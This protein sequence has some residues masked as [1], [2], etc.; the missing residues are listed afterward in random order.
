M[1]LPQALAMSCDTWFY[2][3]GHAAATG[4]CSRA[5]STMQTWARRLGLGHADGAR[6][7]GRVGRLRAD[8]GVAARRRSRSRRG[9]GTR[10][11]RSTSSI[12]QGYLQVTPLQLAVAYAALANGGTVVRPH[13]ADA[14]LDPAGPS[15]AA[16]AR[17]RAE[18]ALVGAAGDPRRALRGRALGAAARRR[19]SSAASRSRSRARPAPPR[20]R[21]AATTPGTRRGRRRATRATSSSC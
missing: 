8:A 11:R 5:T 20:R 9:T 1:S 21:P 4:G 18:A 3:L 16:R 15:S 17:P 7:P 6:R 12:G 10:A 14:V 19:R 2:R 13:V